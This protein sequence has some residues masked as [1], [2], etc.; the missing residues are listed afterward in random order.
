MEGALTGGSVSI[1]EL[2]LTTK[3]LSFSISTSR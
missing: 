1:G 2:S 3:A